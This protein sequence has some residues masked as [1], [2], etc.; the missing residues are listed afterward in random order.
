MKTIAIL[1][2]AFSLLAG[3][4]IS[5]ERSLP[6]RP[7]HEGKVV[8]FG[9][10]HAHSKLSDDV[11]G[12]EDELLPSKAFPYAQQHGLDFLAI[13]DHHKATDSDHTLRMEPDEY[14]TKLFDVAKQY[15]MD[16]AGEFIAIPGIEWGNTATGNHV[17]L[18]GAKMLPPDSIKD[19]EYDEIYTWAVAN[20]EFV[21]FN[22]PK[23]WEGKHPHDETVGNFGEKRYPTIAKFVAGAGQRVRT[24][25]IIS[26]VAGGHI[27]GEH[28]DSE[29]KT[30]REMTSESNYREFLNMGFHISPAANQDTHGPNWGTVTAAR[31]AAW[32][33]GVSYDQLMDAFRANRVYTTEDDELVVAFQ[34]KYNGQTHWM[35]ETVPLDSDEDDVELLVKVWQAA[36]SDGDNTN[37]GPYTI[38]IISDAD[39]IGGQA[40]SPLGQPIKNVPSGT[41]KKIPLSVQ[42]GQYVYI[43]V[44]EQKGKDNL[45]GEGDDIFI[46]ATGASGHDGKRD[47][48]NDSAWTSPVWFGTA[49]T[50]GMFVW[51]VNSSKY[52]DPNCWAIESIGAANR[53][54]GPAPAGKTKHNCHPSP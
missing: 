50:G 40:A 12:E 8:L 29:A 13:T 48:P 10:L 35:G 38:Q 42:R 45:V 37:E 18:I 4:W 2:L 54:T 32:A 14:K 17:N 28:A 16:H 43:Q 19:K 41:L 30:H 24:V 39:G 51:S 47:N 34:V 21:Q 52:H 27:G 1:F 20:C 9:N 5:A 46:N 23:G 49:P 26:S 3:V 36:G 44:T 53:R 7:Q 22:H 6:E 31:T 33:D 25:S 15:N 11:D